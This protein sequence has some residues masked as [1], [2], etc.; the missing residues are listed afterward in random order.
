MPSLS[1]RPNEQQR[2]FLSTADWALNTN[3]AFARGSGRSMAMAIVAIKMAIQG[4]RVH[5]LDPSLVLNHGA[6]SSIHRR[7]ARLVVD[8]AR[9]YFP[10]YEFEVSQLDNTFRCLGTRVRFTPIPVDPEPERVSFDDD[11]SEENM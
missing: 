1:F 7:F 11:G 8:T 10:D 2:E 5:L 4:A 9:S 6:N 3:A